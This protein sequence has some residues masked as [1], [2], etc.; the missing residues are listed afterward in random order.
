M[1]W[2]SIIAGRLGISR[3]TVREIRERCLT[4]GVDWMR[5]K[6]RVLLTDSGVARVAE[7]VKNTAPDAGPP[8]PVPEASAEKNAASGESSAVDGAVSCVDDV[9]AA[10]EKNAAVKRLKV[11]KL[12]LNP[13]LILATDGAAVVR[14]R[15]PDCRNFIK[16]MEFN[17]RL[18]G[19]DLYELVGR[20]PRF[21]GRW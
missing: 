3:D 14:V 15:V 10:A 16:G 11:H 8:E 5:E 2:E 19:G 13:R 9:P 12:V 4:E 17:A 6:K 21:R 7:A 18:I 20:C 1:H